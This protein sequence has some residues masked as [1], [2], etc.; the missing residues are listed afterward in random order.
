VAGQAPAA[1][2]RPALHWHQTK[3]GSDQELRG[4]D[5]VS[6]RTAWVSGDEGGVW[7]TRDAGRHWRNV[8]PPH[9]SKLLFR[10]IEATDARHALLLAVG[11][12]AQSRIYRTTDAGRHWHKVWVNHSPNAFY[13]CM[14]MWRG[15]KRGLAVSDPVHGKFRLMRTR[16]HGR[17]WHLVHPVKMPKAPGEFG[18]AASGTC[19]VTAG[20]KRAWF[21]SG[22]AASRVFRTTDGGRRWSVSDSTIPASAA[23]GTFGLSFRTPRIGLAVGGDF[24]KPHH[25]ANASAFTHN[26]SRR[27]ING[28]DLG[29]YRSAV[30]WVPGAPR[31]AIAVGTSGSDVTHNGG[32]TWTTFGRGFDSVQCV[33]GACWASGS[34]GRVGRMLR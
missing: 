34:H 4:L 33:P 15:G 28:G 11:S 10:D 5:A 13:D 18:F 20:A 23:G 7:L 9:S 17:T 24:T 26:G 16:D 31:T 27:W 2:G 8:S 22:G 1:S 21:A 25:G 3:V 32:R 12:R 14:A 6:A 29:G 19:L 30:D